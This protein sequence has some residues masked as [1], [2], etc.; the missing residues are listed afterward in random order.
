LDL[1]NPSF[2]YRIL[3]DEISLSMLL[4]Q[5]QQWKQIAQGFLHPLHANRQHIDKMELMLCGL[6]QDVPLT[7]QTLARL[8]ARESRVFPKYHHEKLQ[9]YDQY[10]AL[11]QQQ[12]QQQEQQQDISQPELEATR[13]AIAFLEIDWKTLQRTAQLCEENMQFAQTF[14]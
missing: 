14:L 7:L 10:Q 12:Q 13:Q 4:M 8:L 2:D 9:H 5:V 3:Q 1:E 11:L 6:L